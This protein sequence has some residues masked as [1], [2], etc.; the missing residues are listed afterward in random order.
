MD[1]LLK[2][3]T[4]P[5][6]YELHIE[7]A[8]IEKRNATAELEIQRN[9]GGLKIKSRPIKVNIDTYAAR[10]SVVPTTKTAISQAAQRGMEK[11]GEAAATYAQESRQMLRTK[12]G[13]GQKTLQQILEQRASMPTGEFRLDFIPSTGADLS[14]EGPAISIEYQMDKLNFDLQVDQGNIEFIPGSVEV[15]ITQHP[16]VSIE[17]IGQPIYVPPSVAERFTGKQIDVSV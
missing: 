5:I 3:T 4:V 2:I 15:S 8:K 13:E 10:N 17:Y 7:N 11:A 12:N 16:E 14:W 6:K 1:Q 9:Q